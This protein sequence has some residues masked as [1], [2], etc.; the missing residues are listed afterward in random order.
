MPTPYW[1]TLIAAN[2]IEQDSDHGLKAL[3]NQFI[4]EEDE[5]VNRFDTL[6][7]GITFDFIPLSTWCLY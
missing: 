1:D 6:F 7:K 3:Y 2:I 5:G 4:A